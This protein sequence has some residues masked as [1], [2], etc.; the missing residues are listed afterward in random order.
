M[1]TARASKSKKKV[2]VPEIREDRDKMTAPG[3]LALV[4]AGEYL[5]GMV[6][7]DRY[8]LSTLNVKKPKVVVMPTAAAQEEDYMKWAYMG[9]SHFQRLGAD[10]EAAL[11]VD[12]ES[13]NDHHNAELVKEADLVYMSGGDPRYLLNTLKN[14][15]VWESALEVYGRGG[16]LAGCSAGAMVM[17][18]YVRARG[19]PGADPSTLWL[20]GLNLIPHI[21]IMPHFDRVTEE[22]LRPITEHLPHDAAIIGIDEHTA[23]VGSNQEWQVRGRGKVAIITGSRTITYRSG[24]AFELPWPTKAV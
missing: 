22:R 16:V 17:G 1:V 15:S 3:V 24:E 23:I 8:L 12:H 5:S 21:V 6:E 14:S 18:Q 19:A 20:A 7:I 9:L 2:S 13:A 10:V 11:V 4:G